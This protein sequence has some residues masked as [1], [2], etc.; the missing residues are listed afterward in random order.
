MYLL[1]RKEKVTYKTEPGEEVESSE[2]S[3][4]W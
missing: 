4:D 1:V 2:G 3:V